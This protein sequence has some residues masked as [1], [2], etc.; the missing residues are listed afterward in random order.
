MGWLNRWT[1]IPET[2]TV[3]PQI[4]QADSLLYRDPS[5]KIPETPKSLGMKEFK[6]SSGQIHIEEES[7]GSEDK[8][9]QEVLEKPD[10]TPTPPEPNL[11]TKPEDIISYCFGFACPEKHIQETFDKISVDGFKQRRA[12]QKCG[13]LS[14]PCIVKQIAE[15]RWKC[16]NLDS[17]IMAQVRRWNAPPPDWGWTQAGYGSAL[18]AWN[19]FEFFSYLE[20]KPPILRKRKTAE[21]KVDKWLS[22]N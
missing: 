2:E 5:E 12:C 8:D 20:P 11:N 18:Y 9:L 22:K 13:K 10:P 3:R 1:R 6:D 14:E 15:A 21:Q 16:R 4:V 19:K 7:L 17:V